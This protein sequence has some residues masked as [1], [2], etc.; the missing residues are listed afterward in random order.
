M[1]VT[2]ELANGGAVAEL[3]TPWSSGDTHRALPLDLVFKLLKHIFFIFIV[4]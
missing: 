1:H 3:S 4:T 2:Y